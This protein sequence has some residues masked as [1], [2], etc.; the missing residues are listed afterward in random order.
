MQFPFV[1]TKLKSY[2]KEVSESNNLTPEDGLAWWYCQAALLD[3]E[4]K[5]TIEQSITNGPRDL[6]CD[7]VVI[8]R[9]NDTVYI[10]QT[11]LRNSMTSNS[12]KRSEV[13]QLPAIAQILFNKNK[14]C[15]EDFLEQGNPK[16]KTRLTEAYKCIQNNN[17]KLVLVYISTGKI[18]EG[19]IR[20]G[21]NQIKTVTNENVG[22]QHRLKYIF[23]D[24]KRTC[25]IYESFEYFVPSIPI[26]NVDLVGA[27][28]SPDNTSDQDAPLCKVFTTTAKSIWT[29]FNEHRDRLFARNIRLSVGSESSVNKDIRETILDKP[30]S[31]FYMNNGITIL[32]TS[33]DQINQSVQITSPQIINGQQTTRTI[34]SLKRDSIRKDAHILVK[35]ISPRVNNEKTFKKYRNFILD[36]IRASNSQ[37][38][39]NIS[40]LVS[41]NKEHVEIERNLLEKKWQYERKKGSYLTPPLRI[42]RPIGKFS[43]KDLALCVLANEHDPQIAPSTGT[44]QIF[45]TNSKEHQK[46]YEDV[47]DP[48]K[49][50][51]VYLLNYLTSQLST[52]PKNKCADRNIMELHARGRWYVSNL[53]YRLLL[54]KFKK[55]S[56]RVL[57][58]LGHT[59]NRR[60]SPDKNLKKASVIAHSC[61]RKFFNATGGA[62]KDNAKDFF[63][64]KNASLKKWN[65]FFSRSCKSEIKEINRKI[66]KAIA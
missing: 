58:A 13:L 56:K 9:P 46:Y 18:T 59:E 22:I 65:N 40:E 26:V 38:K 51:D 7:I 15:F 24:G 11:K 63:K 44:R 14:R 27:I 10:C 47:F 62:F 16:V 19:L 39:I 37:N 8:S 31:F 23:I 5:V 12:E 4:D 55:N 3:P 28:C 49:K 66:N 48:Y 36:V 45:D 41:N 50:T 42:N 53:L 17:F 6:G 29:L 57:E 64:T 54:K 20:A 35:V 32:A 21:N 1:F 25:Q 60:K 43:I 34:G 33:I 61:W 30:D 52:L 2:V